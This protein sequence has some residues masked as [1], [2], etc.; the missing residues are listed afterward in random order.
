MQSAAASARASG[1][2]TNIL[3][4]LRTKSN[5][6]INTSAQDANQENWLPVAELMA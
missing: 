1:G 6:T 2:A 3:L 5:A 4:M